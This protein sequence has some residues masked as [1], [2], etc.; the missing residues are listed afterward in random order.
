MLRSHS[1]VAM[2]GGSLRGAGTPTHNPRLILRLEEGDKILDS[3]RYPTR[4]AFNLPFLL[5]LGRSSCFWE[6]KYSRII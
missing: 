4:I 5:Y 1:W 2:P 6:L 3:S